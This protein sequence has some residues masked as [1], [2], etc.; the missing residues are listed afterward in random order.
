M[1]PKTI[2]FAC[3]LVA[4][5]ALG[6][7]STTTTETSTSTQPTTTVTR[8]TTTTTTEE[9]MR[10]DSTHLLTVKSF[11]PGDKIAVQTSPDTNP[12]TIRLDHAISYVDGSGAP[13]SPSSIQ[14]GSH[15]RL[16]F[17]GSGP[18]RLVIRIVMVNPK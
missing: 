8:E 16:E 14:P 15:V 13:I 11:A 6:Q 9:I 3:A 2:A 18:D 12:V 17:A 7:V 4:P 5:L 10:L 1:R